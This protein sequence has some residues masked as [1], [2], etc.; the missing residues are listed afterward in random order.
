MFIFLLLH[1]LN[2]G[3]YILLPF[4]FQGKLQPCQFFHVS[5]DVFQLPFFRKFSR[6]LLTDILFYF[7]ILNTRGIVSFYLKS[8]ILSCSAAFLYLSSAH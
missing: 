3:F 1:D 8:S 7:L 4:M 6:L 2:L 5:I